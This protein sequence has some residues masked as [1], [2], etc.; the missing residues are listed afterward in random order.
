MKKLI[1]KGIY[2]EVSFWQFERS[3]VATLTEKFLLLVK[4]HV[5]I[6]ILNFVYQRIGSAL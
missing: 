2:F 5:P 6:E 3:K 4:F 1:L